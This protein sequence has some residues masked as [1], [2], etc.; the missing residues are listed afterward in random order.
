MNS[1]TNRG[2]A[3]G[4]KLNTLPKLYDFDSIDQQFSLFE[5]IVKIMTQKAK[6]PPVR[7][8]DNTIVLPLDVLK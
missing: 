3:Y 8:F 6:T 2:N 4:V 5:Y 1:N 7:Y